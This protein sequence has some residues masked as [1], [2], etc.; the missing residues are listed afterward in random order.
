VGSIF[1]QYV[2]LAVPERVASLSLLGG[3]YKFANRKGRIDKLDQVVTDDFASIGA[4]GVQLDPRLHAAVRD[5]LLECESMDPRTG[6]RYIDLFAHGSDLTHRLDGIDVPT[7]V[8]QGRHDSVVGLETG[9][10]IHRSIAGS[11]YV[12]LDRSGHFVCFTE[13]DRVNDLV[14]RFIRQHDHVQSAERVG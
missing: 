14:A 8:L 12:E 10:F 7:L 5:L 2:A 9:R 11:E 3:S 4:G 1:A 13:P 6:L